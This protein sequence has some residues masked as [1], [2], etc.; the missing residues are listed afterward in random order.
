MEAARKSMEEVK[1]DMLAEVEV[2]EDTKR[3]QSKMTYKDSKPADPGCV[4]PYK[5][6]GTRV[7][8]HNTIKEEE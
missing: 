4:Q 2:N 8:I 6:E 3:R 5:E 1:G 7:S